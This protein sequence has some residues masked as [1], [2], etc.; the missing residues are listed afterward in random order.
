MCD[1][2]YIIKISDS[3]Y[4]QPSHHKPIKEGVVDEPPDATTRHQLVSESSY[5]IMPNPVTTVKREKFIRQMDSIEKAVINFLLGGVVPTE[6]P[7]P[8]PADKKII[9]AVSSDPQVRIPQSIRDR[10]VCIP[11]T[12]AKSLP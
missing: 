5:S 4:S 7:P 3:P 6:L 9:I 2:I 8:P 10:T 11:Y 12:P 1:K